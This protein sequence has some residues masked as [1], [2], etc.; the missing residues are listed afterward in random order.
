M[1]KLFTLK[2][3]F[4]FILFFSC[5][6]QTPQ[7]TSTTTIHSIREKKHVPAIAALLWENGQ[8]KSYEVSGLRKWGEKISVT[9]D[10]LFHL[11]SCTKAMTATLVGI[12]V[13]EGKLSWNSTI[14]ELL[15]NIKNMNPSF[16]KVTLEMLLAHRSGLEDNEFSKKE[17]WNKFSDP[18][19]APVTE[20]RFLSTHLLSL[21]PSSPPGKKFIYSN[22]GYVILGHILEKISKRSW[23]SL[24]QEKLFTPLGMKTCGFGPAA[25]SKATIPDQ[26]LGHIKNEKGLYMAIFGDNPPS[27]GP[28]G[29]VHCSLPDW[30]KFVVMHLSS[31]LGNNHFLS[32]STIQKLHTPYPGQEYTFGGWN[33]IQTKWGGTTF[34]HDGNNTL[35]FARAAWSSEK[36]KV[37]LVTSNSGT[38]EGQE[39]VIEA[40][41][42]FTKK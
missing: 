33:K 37:I 17:F 9:P 8:V 20:R 27:M 31:E 32:Q 38:K 22:S 14:D 26:P 25:N 18:N 29:T 5:S 11:G 7:T 13:D 16:R 30:N 4:I 42:L 35:N 3:L 10:D 2:L 34:Y 21:P 36:N 23:E 12:F 24:M 40:F 19:T 1:K 28:A 6:F 41:L 39:A 15:P